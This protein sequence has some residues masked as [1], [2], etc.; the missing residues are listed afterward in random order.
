MGKDKFH[1]VAF[2]FCMLVLTAL[3]SCNVRNAVQRAL[4]LP[5]TKPLNISKTVVS[6]IKTCDYADELMVPSK[7]TVSPLLFA[8]V[9]SIISFIFPDLIASLKRGVYFRQLRLL[10]YSTPLFILYRKILI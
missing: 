6:S 8:V 9:L 10:P 7:S 3:L 1:R 4:D 2:L 5:T